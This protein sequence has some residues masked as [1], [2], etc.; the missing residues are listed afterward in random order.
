VSR[1]YFTYFSEH[2][3]IEIQTQEVRIQ[4]TDA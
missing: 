4:T 1:E 3:T 2:K